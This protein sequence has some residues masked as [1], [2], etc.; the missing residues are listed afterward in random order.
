MFQ[1]PKWIRERNWQ[2]FPDVDKIDCVVLTH[3]HID[4]SGYLPKIFKDGFSGPVYCTGPTSDLCEIMLL[5]SAHIQMEDAKFALAKRHSR[6]ETPQPLYTDR[7]A[8]QAIE[9]L[10]ACSFDEWKELF[11]GISVRFVRS[12]HILGSA[13]VQFAYDKGNGVKILTF[14]G[15]IGH[16]RQAVI[17]SPDHLIET[18]Y[19]VLEST[20][21]DRRHPKADTLSELEKVTFDKGG[22]LVIPAFAVGRAQEI[23][24]LL[25]ILK[26]AKRIPNIPIYLDSPMAN[27]ATDVY[28][29]YPE[30]QKLRQT[31]GGFEMPISS[32]DFIATTSTDESMLLCMKDDEPMIII[33][34]AGMLSGG[35]ILHHLRTRLPY[36]KNTVL[37]VGYQAQGTKGRLL[38]SGIPKIRLH[39]QEVDIE[40]EV[41]TIQSLSAHGDVNDIMA[42]LK[43][44]KKTPKKIFLNHGETDA[45]EA[46][47]YQISYELETPVEIP[48]QLDQFEL[49]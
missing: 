38:Q 22:T 3:A 15:D 13:F 35:R 32:K 10:V 49:V 36:E 6:H 43:G 17:R 47:K 5:D 24:Y 20:Y 4:H 7:D 26:E 25:K 33:S 14:S 44:F 12:G 37:F 29:K 23:I 9:H 16:A 40:A 46:L 34:A 18:D 31:P 21:G 1:G 42:W 28:L 27:R 8:H 45:L 41:A 2:T 19:L 30:E 48:D 39:H 11:P